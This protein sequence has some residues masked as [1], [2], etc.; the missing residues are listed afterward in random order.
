MQGRGR[1]D[2]GGPARRVRADQTVLAARPRR[3]SNA[4]STSRVSRHHVE[5]GGLVGASGPGQRAA[6]QS[7]DLSVL[8]HGEQR[9]FARHRKRLRQR[10]MSGENE[11]R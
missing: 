9:R 3:Q 10:R 1:S 7:R 11:N 2:Q 8:W 4:A 5:L 6:R